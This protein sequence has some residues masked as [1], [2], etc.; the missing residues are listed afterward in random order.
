MSIMRRKKSKIDERIN[1][2]LGKEAQFEGTLTFDGVVKIDSHFKGEIRAKSGTL[3]VGNEGVV[4]ADI[5]AASVLCS[6][7]IRGQ[8]M[9]DERVNIQVPGK[10]FGNIC[11]PTVIIEEGVQLEG[12]CK[13]ISPGSDSAPTDSQ[14][15]RSLQSL[16]A[17]APTVKKEKDRKKTG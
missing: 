8:I 16:P 7:E 12:N 4:E 3:I 5:H 2:F 6:G 10:V 11:S 9:A 14:G 17:S 1:S 13:T 15:L